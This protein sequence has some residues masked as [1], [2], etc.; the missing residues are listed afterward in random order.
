[1]A[2]LRQ[3]YV[4]QLPR[5]LA[6]MQSLLDRMGDG[7]AQAGTHTYAD[8]APA[9]ELF[10]LLH[11]LKGTGRSLGFS[12]LGSYAEQGEVLLQDRPAQWR[13]LLQKCLQQLLSTAQEQ[14]LLASNTPGSGFALVNDPQV[15][16]K[17]HGRL[18][19][20]CDDEAIMLEQLAAQLACFGYEA[21]GF[22]DP[23]AL[24]Q[25]F[26][27]RRPDAVI[28]DV[29]FPQGARAGID[30]LLKLREETGA[31]VPAVFLSSRSDFD[32]RLGAVRAGG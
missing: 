12:L 17:A 22:T 32:A 9:A 27:Q 23:Q 20:L 2:K 3:T 24:R 8:G 10:R 13:E 16:A 28:M 11:N 18:V 5:Q 15:Q 21:R 14:A 7:A 4:L 19:Y 30:V 29:H 25:A 26:L 1:M 31:P 6:H